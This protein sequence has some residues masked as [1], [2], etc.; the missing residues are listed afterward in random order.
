MSLNPSFST[1]LPVLLLLM[2]NT[3]GFQFQAHTCLCVAGI[4]ANPIAWS[5]YYIVSKKN[6]ILAAK[7]EPLSLV[8]SINL[9]RHVSTCSISGGF[10]KILNKIPE[11]FKSQNLN[12]PRAKHNCFR[13]L[14]N[15]SNDDDMWSEGCCGCSV[16]ST[17][18]LFLVI[19]S[20]NKYTKYLNIYHHYR[21]NND[22]MGGMLVQIK[23]LWGKPQFGKKKTYLSHR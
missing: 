8:Y 22:T 9:T 17:F 20:L 12:F 2:S 16:P 4:F 15:Y 3:F 21:R 10:L 11:S 14:S 19:H 18:R 1:G 5:P 13:S 23:T 7:M 6:S